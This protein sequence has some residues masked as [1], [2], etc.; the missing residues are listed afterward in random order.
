MT[1]HV[2]PEAQRLLDAIAATPPLDTLSVR[3]IRENFEKAASLTGDA[4][5][6]LSV[7]DTK[8]AGVPVRVYTPGLKNHPQPCVV[9]FH[10]GGWTTG[11]LDLAE[12]TIREIAAEAG[13]IGISVDYRLAPE[14]PFPATID[15]A[16][17][18]VSAVLSGETDLDIDIEKVGVV[19]DSAGGNIAA[20]VA[21]QMRGHRPGLVH[22][23]L[24]YPCT[25]LSNLHS[26][27]YQ[28]YGEGY[29]LSARNLNWYI[30]Q[31]TQPEEREDVRASPALNSDLTNLPPATIITA[32][33]DPLRDQGEAYGRA[34][35]QQG[36]K[37]STVRFLGQPHLFLQA[38][39]LI[40]D[41]H[42]A[43]R[44]LGRQLKSSFQS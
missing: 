2:H 38:G 43:R 37:V 39:A 34:L 32:E 18:V 33:C 27:S 7:E 14:H 3:Q 26:P 15:D 31:Y 6:M 9:Y 41:A 36:N 23:G 30:D 22:Q 35:G 5:G 40:N 11:T 12:S 4:V 44:L 1:Q 8:I 10:G 21:Q 17:A 42:T 13:A 29:F 24:I 25:D 16:I 19:G 20:V 28:E